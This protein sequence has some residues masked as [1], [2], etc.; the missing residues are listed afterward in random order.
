MDSFG[1]DSNPLPL[2][3][4]E[5]SFLNATLWG[6]MV[7]VAGQVP[8]DD[9]GSLITGRV[10]EPDTDLALAV[11][12]AERCAVRC[13]RAAR[14]VVEYETIA[15]VMKTLVIVNCTDEFDNMP[16]VAEGASKVLID[17]LG[18]E[19]G[20]GTRMAFGG[21]PPFGALVEVTMTFAVNPTQ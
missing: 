4:L 19:V 7:E 18:E 13:L 5:F 8:I 3:H 14:A 11:H 16:A 2:K 1:F 9:Q 15:R 12:A 10:G 6:G 17:I 20:M 21:R